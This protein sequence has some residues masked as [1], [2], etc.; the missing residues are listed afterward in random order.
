MRT[1][2]GARAAADLSTGAIGATVRVAH[3]ARTESERELSSRHVEIFQVSRS[4]SKST[5]LNLFRV[6]AAVTSAR[7]ADGKTPMESHPTKLTVDFDLAFGYLV[8]VFVVRGVRSA[9]F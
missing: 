8:M 9:I 3:H 1:C 7:L 2:E 6:Q 4:R 5:W